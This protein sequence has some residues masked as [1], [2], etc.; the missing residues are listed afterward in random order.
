[1]KRKVAFASLGCDKNTVD[2]EIMLSL[3]TE[4]G[5][6]ITKNDE[7]AEAAVINT[8][9]FIQDAQE[10]AIQT[11]IEMGQYKETGALK[12]LI[13]TG[14]LAQRYADEM[15]TE[16]PEVDAVVGTGS[17]EKIVEALDR[18][19]EQKEKEVR[20]LDAL[21]QR[22]LG[23][24]KR[25]L[26][27]PGYY[28]Y[29]KIG[30]GCDNRCTYC[31]I[32]YLRGPYR[33]RPKEAILKEAKDLADA[34]VK[35]VMLV[36]QDIT[37]Y[38]MDFSEHYRLP[39]LLR[40]LVK[41]DGIEWIRLLYCY[42]EDVTD[43]LIDVMASEKKILP[44][45]DIPIQHSC[46]TVLKRMNRKHT[47]SMLEELLGKLRR[48]MPEITI[49]TTLITGFPGETEQEFEEMLSFVQ[50][51]R[52][53]RLGVFT[54]SCEEGTPAARMKDQ[55]PE[56]IRE[57]RKDMVMELQRQI[58]E[59]KS[60]LF[61]GKEMEALIEGRIPGEET[62]DGNHIYS[63]RTYRDAPEIDGFLFVTTDRELHSGDMIRVLVTGS[64]EYDLIGEAVFTEEDEL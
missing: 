23:Y 17:Y 31:I 15:F 50:E 24:Q 60:A 44:Y 59:E 58:S 12:A 48:K 21:D 64:Y 39:D 61:V 32:P 41:I 30:M 53:D 18:V 33:S 5:Y 1:M 19:L 10:E 63:A 56:E 13:V 8:C 26:I 22:P 11:I 54:Y 42:P 62:E 36:A 4:H 28:E 37:K 45:I 38:G 20:I 55:I 25:T 7:E 16:M 40:D 49:R 27:T 51:A 14:C 43:E 35:E 34:G 52:F 47:R 57:K 3:L 29:L 6:E 2:S 9:A 46:D